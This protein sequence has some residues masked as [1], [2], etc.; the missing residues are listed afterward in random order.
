[1]KKIVVIAGATKGL[2]KEL[3]LSFSRSGYEVIG[4]YHADMATAERVRDEFA[5]SQLRGD[6]L[7]LDIAK[8]GGW[9]EFNAIID[10]KAGRHFTLFANASA[11]FAPK[12]FHTLDWSEISSLIDVNVKGTFALTQR[13]LPHMVKARA[14]RIVTILSEAVDDTP[15]GFSGYVIAKSA[16][17]GLTRC[18][19]EEYSSR[20]IHVFSVSPGFMDTSLTKNWSEHLKA[21]IFADPSRVTSPAVVAERILRICEDPGTKG[22]G[23][24]YLLRGNSLNY[25]A[26][27]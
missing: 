24:N 22:Q 19:A 5:A 13:L 11:P 17:D 6:F 18:L 7:K 2:G 12:P 27:V 1:M 16:L 14:G 21:M 26:G 20:G 25:F 9:D 3:A 15:K 8:D 10:S 4:L 23:E